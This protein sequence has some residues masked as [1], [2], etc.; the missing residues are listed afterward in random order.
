MEEEEERSNRLI[1]GFNLIWVIGF[2]LIRIGLGG[3]CGFYLI[4]NTMLC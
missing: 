3:L 4:L 1:L 2:F